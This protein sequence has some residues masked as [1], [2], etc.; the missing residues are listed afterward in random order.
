MNTKCR[1]YE[2]EVQGRVQRIQDEQG[3]R[4]AE[5]VYH[6]W[7]PVKSVYLGG[8]GTSS[9]TRLD[10]AY[11]VQGQVKEIKATQLG[12]GKVLYQEL[13]GYEAKVNPAAGVPATLESR[14]SG[15]ITQQLTK[16]ASDINTA[17]Q[18]PVRL[19]NYD[20]DD[21]GRML[22]VEAHV[23]SNATPLDAAENINFTAL[24]MASDPSKSTALNYDLNGRIT[25]QRTAGTA[26]ADSARYVYKVAS[27]KLDQVF[28]KLSS[29]S[30]RAMAAA[31]TFQYDANGNL[32]RDVSRNLDVAYDW[33]GMPVKFKL[34]T[35]AQYQL[36]DADGRRATRLETVTPSGGTE[37]R[38]RASH[39]VLLSGLALREVR[40]IYS[41][42]GTA[43]T[44]TQEICA[45][46]GA[47]GQIGRSRLAGKAGIAEYDFF[48]KNHLG[49]TMRTVRSDGSYATQ[50]AFDYMPYGDPKN[51]RM[52]SDGRPVT[53]K[54]TG[55]EYEDLTKLYYFGARFFDPELGIWLT[56][57]GAGQFVNPYAYGG[58][59][60][61]YFDPD[62]LIRLGLGVSIGWTNKGG[63]SL[64][65]G[66]GVQDLN[67]GGF[68]LNTYA[69]ADHNFKDDSWTYSAS[70]GAGA[71]KGV[72]GHA[73]VGY[74]YNDK[75]GSSLHADVG[76]G[77]GF[78]PVETGL[79]VGTNQN[80]NTNGDYIGGDVYGELYA[81]AGLVR[82]TAGYSHGFGATQSGWY[83]GVNMGG[84]SYRYHSAYGS[85][86]GTKTT[87]ATVGYDT[88]TG[89]S[90]GDYVGKGLVDAVVNYHR[91]TP[92]A[93]RLAGPGE[94]KRYGGTNWCGTGGGGA[95]TGKVCEGC[96]SH[97]MWY[98]LM[99]AEGLEGAFLNYSMELIVA[100]F[101]LAGNSWAN[102][103][104]Q[105]WAGLEVGFTYSLISIYKFSARISQGARY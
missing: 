46:L 43:V 96:G 71:C 47:K 73:G 36:Y 34:G 77:V 48:I 2:Y 65:V 32:V 53:E 101:A 29:T 28:G 100:D 86:Y 24:T 42:T 59:P 6:N 99:G 35:A 85:N 39:Y 56:P 9:G 37:R 51:I 44:D 30:T 14:Y 3:Q 80:W 26:A 25:G 12:T 102:I 104:D 70:V 22:R 31:G 27:H 8:S 93:A 61:N 55:K 10:Y 23:N 1:H 62:G 60:I 103:G 52:G 45:L 57:D 63:F 90:R 38:V 87:L 68:S 18:K 7:G 15:Q 74:S 13:L 67:V 20:Y 82:A 81:K 84:L 79:E 98:E 95:F 40:E 89:E 21:L 94:R 72:C 92:P 50:N 16:F 41:S 78:G 19:A 54:F 91:K 49:S 33:E 105:P 76:V 83:S 58:D 66:L 69:G 88:R 5:F 17:T 4:I 75:S 11:H 64:G 97:D